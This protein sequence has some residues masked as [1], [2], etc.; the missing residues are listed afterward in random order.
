MKLHEATG[1]KLYRK[2]EIT[3]ALDYLTTERNILAR[4]LKLAKQTIATQQAR[5]EVLREPLMAAR[6]LA[7]KNTMA[8]R[9]PECGDFGAI[10]QDLDYVCSQLFPEPPEQEGE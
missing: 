3:Q 8:A 10:A 5:I 4:D 6:S 9:I 7:M 2:E 1:L